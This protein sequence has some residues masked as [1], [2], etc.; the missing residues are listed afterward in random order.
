MRIMICLQIPHNVLNRWKNYFSQLTNVHSVGAVKLIKISTT[1][2]LLPDPCPFEIENYIAE[3][4][5][6]NRQILIKF[7]QNWFK[8]E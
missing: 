6:I 3:L 4:K 5:G 7:K 8:Q 1:E 2:L